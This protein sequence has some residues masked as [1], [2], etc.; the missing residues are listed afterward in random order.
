MVYLLKM[1]IFYSFL[2]VYQ[3]VRTLLAGTV[4]TS[5]VSGNL[6]EQGRISMHIITIIDTLPSIWDFHGFPVAMQQEL[7]EDLR[8]GT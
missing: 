3:R 1:V 8:S 2:Y 6:S 4:W 5:F 7:L